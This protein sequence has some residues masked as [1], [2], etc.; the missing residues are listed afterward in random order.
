MEFDEIL[1][2][3][4]GWLRKMFSMGDDKAPGHDVI[5]AIEAGVDFKG[6][7]LWILVL[8]I[9]VASLGLNTNSAAVIIGAMLISPLMGPIIGMGLGVGIND[10]T[11][12]KRAAKNYLIATLFSVAT[13]TLYF[14]I[15][16]FDE[17]QSE[18]LARTSPT[19]YDVGIALC[20][21]LAGIIALS[22][23][24]QRTGNVIP[25]VAIATALMPPLCTVGFGLGTGN[26]LYALGALY[27]YFINTI[28][29]SLATFVGVAFVM[30]YPKKQ[31]VDKANERR[32][33]RI[34]TFICIITIIPSLFITFKIFQETVFVDRCQEFCRKAV[35]AKDANLIS[36]DFDYKNKAIH[37]VF[38]GNEVDSLEIE[39][40]SSLLPEY[41]LGDVKLDVVQ[42]AKNFDIESIRGLIHSEKDDV[43]LAKRQ[44]AEREQR[45]KEVGDSLN[46][47]TNSGNLSKTLMPELL[48]LFP[49][50]SSVYTGTGV[51]T[52]K[53]DSLIADSTVCMVYV[54]FNGDI[55][56]EEENRMK[57]WLKTR[58]HR[59]DVEVILKQNEDVEPVN[60]LG[61][62]YKK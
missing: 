62:P 13:A 3:I 55:S 1:K 42:G 38:I 29:I 39:Y 26:L 19:I 5:S 33:K 59:G 15:T 60:P 41:G 7:K 10:F 21:G 54:V 49:G 23:R 47:Y 27:L 22:S 36:S 45:L 32:V 61:E 9:F 11:L 12:F 17:V 4:K 52:F 18:L 34:I 24:S 50:I 20:G 35:K 16:P 37:L 58:L 28:F 53:G 48:S 43:M 40:M 31:F 44:L 6:A 25:G 51:Q 46:N 2:E 56:H 8:A 57:L 14:L 30:R